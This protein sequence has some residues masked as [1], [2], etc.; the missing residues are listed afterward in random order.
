MEAFTNAILGRPFG[1]EPKSV[2]I[3]DECQIAKP[4]I[5]TMLRQ[6]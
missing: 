6:E 5:L 4:T 1:R 3:L 2:L